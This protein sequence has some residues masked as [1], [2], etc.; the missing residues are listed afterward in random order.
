MTSTASSTGSAP[1]TVSTLGLTPARPQA[2]A[3]TFHE[4]GRKQSI[5]Y[6]KLAGE[7]RE[8]AKGLVGLGVAPG[9]R[10]GIL[11]T[12]RAEWVIADLAILATGAIVVPIYQTNA[13]EECQHVIKDSGL[14]VLFVED[15][16]QLKKL[17]ALN[18]DVAD[19]ATVIAFED[20][21][22]D[23]LTLDAVKA[24]GAGV[25][26][27]EIDARASAV[28]PSDPATIV[29]TSGTTGLPKGV[30]LTHGNLE[31]D[32]AMTLHRLPQ[33]GHERFFIFLP[34][35]HVLTRIVALLAL[36]AGVELIFWQRDPKKLLD[37]VAEAK[38][39]TVPSVP[40]LFEKIY[41]A[42]N[43]KSAEAGGAK[44]AIFS[45]AV[46]TGRR[47]LELDRAGKPIGPLLKL[48]HGLADKLVFSKI[49]DLFGGEIEVCITGAAPV[50][51]EILDFFFAAGIPVLEGY[52]MTETS[53]VASVNS[54]EDY[55]VGTVGKPI[56]GCEVKIADDGE[57]LMRG[58]NVFTAYWNNEEATAKDL[59]DGWLHSGDLGEIDHDG[60]LKI[61]GRKKDLIITS[62][63]KNIAPSHLENLIRQH[64]WVSQCVIY[65]D[66]KQFLT[67]MIT[68]DPD[69]VAALGEAV[70]AP[71]SSA[72][73]L[74][75]NPAAIAE[76][77]AVIEAANA[78]VAKIAG[79][80]KFFILERDLTQDHGEMTPTLKVKRN[81]VYKEHEARFLALYEGAK[82]E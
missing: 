80:K 32:V 54:T 23:V 78:K 82:A 37:E 6:A 10:V 60:F 56:V 8:V 3:L 53:A 5:D 25:D 70:G 50:D 75:T 13:P 16:S 17:D 74:S 31:S 73:D 35:A 27:A 36:T 65:G 19:L 22:G 51:P 45:R 63:G 4:G 42:A 62:S 26:G 12:T 79:V 47:K 20:A 66:R 71:G 7:V 1:G 11:S 33:A 18:G 61:T 44:A 39:T 76:I 81:V 64:R 52:G 72:A 59:S 21:T 57:V 67:A 49:R 24:K 40:R 38:P 28:A 41:T 2:T 34:L 77:D 69:E 14:T 43:A 55:R 15:G 46:A 29:Y 9:D 48:Q 68:L 58:P 30:M